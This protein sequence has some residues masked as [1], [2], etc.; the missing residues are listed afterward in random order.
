MKTVVKVRE[1]DYVGIVEALWRIVT[2]E[3][4]VRRTRIEK[5]EE[6][7]W[8]AGVRQLYRGASLSFIWLILGD[9]LTVKGQF[10]MAATAHAEKK[11]SVN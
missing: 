11:T 1:R 8:F 2:E 7:G 10:G 4:G 5:G 3:T 9:R 6:G